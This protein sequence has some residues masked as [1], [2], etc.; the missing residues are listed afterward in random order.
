MNL[1]RRG[2]SLLL[3]V[4][5]SLNLSAC[6]RRHEAE[7]S[8]SAETEAS[9]EQQTAETPAEPTQEKEDES[10]YP[11]S[12]EGAEEIQAAFDQF[13]HEEFISQLEDDYLSIHYT[14]LN[15]EDYGIDLSTAEISLGDAVSEEYLAEARTE[16]QKL[17]EQFE[18]FDYEMLT[19]EQQETYLLYEYLLNLAIES[20]SE[21]FAYMGGAFTPMQGLQNDIASLLMEFD[22]YSE[23]DV[24]AYLTMMRDVPRY[25]EDTLEYTKVQAEKGYFMPDVSAQSTMEY[26]QKI[27]REGENSALLTAVI[28]NIEQCVHLG[29]IQIAQYSTEVR[30]IFRDCI[31][32]AYQ[33]IYDTIGSL[34]GEKNN[35]LGLAWMDNGKEYY[36]YL[37]RVKTGSDR[38]VDEAKQLLTEYLDGAVNTISEIAV[39]NR[40]AYR[41]YL[42][43]GINTGYDGIGSILN[44]LETYVFD[45]FPS[46]DYVDYTVSYLDSQ[47]AVDGISAYYV[48]P[49][50]DSTVTQK[51]KVNPNSSV[52]ITSPSTF[53]TLAHEGLPGHLYQTNYVLQNLDDPFRQTTSILGYSEGYATYV[54]LIALNYL[55][56]IQQDEDSE[57]AFEEDEVT[58]EQ[59]YTLFENCLIALCDI[60]IHYEGWTVSDMENFLSQYTEME[61]AQSIYNQLL[62]DP[63]G[64][65]SYYMG[66]VEFLELRRTA[67]EELGSRFNEMDFHETILQGG[68]L[69]F[70]LL[71]QNVEDYI[72]LKKP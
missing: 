62:G 41:A 48:V 23:E 46:I 56:N 67:Q 42:Y 47:V 3:A 25:V 15:P 13:I 29:D 44:D 53:R 33:K 2:L 69:P 50:L 22:F 34:M 52:D 55:N 43:Q 36:E 18:T 58:L 40:P 9:Q 32:P 7:T 49:P 61:Y 12:Y 8:P 51:I 14:L 20:M 21:D 30:E 37:F 59:C 39:S 17:K 16:N 71:K 24:R 11:T 70:S 64:F 60:G 6:Q 19:E 68:D 72:R 27:I 35:Q 38:S 66:C 28:H 63:A 4:L 10:S 31:L 57:Y 45:N 26:C 1:T 54:E 5:L 65:L